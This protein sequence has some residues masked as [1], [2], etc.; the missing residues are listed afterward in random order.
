[1]RRTS[2]LFLIAAC[3]DNHTATTAP[4][5]DATTPVADATPDALMIPVGLTLR[6]DTYA[7]DVTADGTTAVF[8]RVALSGATIVFYDTVLGVASDRTTLPDPSVDLA[9][10]V[11]NDLR[12]SA[13]YDNPVVG[14]I[15]SDAAS[16]WLTLPSPHATGCDVFSGGAFDISGDGKTATGLLYNGCATE[17]FRWTDTGGAGTM[18]P[19]EVLGTPSNNAAKSDRGS[20]IS[21]DGRIIAG[22]A[23]NG[24]ADRTPAMWDA[25]NHG[26]LLDPTNVDLPGE[27]LAIDADGGVLAGTLGN[28][29][30]VW[31]AAA[32][33]VMLPAFD[34]A[35]P[36]A[37]SFA[38]ATSADGSTIFGEIGDGFSLTPPTAV[39]W[40]RTGTSYTVTTLA[41]VCTA[42]G[43]SVPAGFGF[44]NI[45]GA[46]ADGR[47]LV[48]TAASDT[49]FDT[50]VLQLP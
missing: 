15:W 34:G 28:Q 37:S 1:M 27:V 48:G 41:D 16:A 4:M 8:E 26:S 23:A 22:F 44:T 35:D 39:I 11:S 2:L 30:F 10:G 13:E 31:T 45:M 43:I 17:A 38:N 47:S 46:S 24:G 5:P 50:F 29:A 25:N 6:D 40:K 42:A 49:V 19:L 14:G 18:T 32:G 36:G 3:G 12:I 21:R 20:V 33:F 9:T 7:I